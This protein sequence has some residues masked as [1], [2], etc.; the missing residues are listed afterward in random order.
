MPPHERLFQ[1][2]AITLLVISLGL[3]IA[4]ATLDYR[5]GLGAGTGIYQFGRLLLLGTGGLAIW[6]FKWAR[7]KADPS[8]RKMPKIA[9]AM[10]AVWI[11]IAGILIVST[12]LQ[13][14]S[15]LF[16][17]D[18]RLWNLM[19]AVVP[20]VLGA[21]IVAYFIVRDA[22]RSELNKKAP[23]RSKAGSYRRK[24]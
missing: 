21:C 20:L 15:R 5:D 23:P 1:A 10:Y 14:Q 8:A 11:V 7:G 24:R 12:Q 19:V 17:E 3:I 13:A 2:A 4:G 16:V 18:A 22:V 9:T 6:Y